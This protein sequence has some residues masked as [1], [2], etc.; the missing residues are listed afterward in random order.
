VNQFLLKQLIGETKIMF[1]Q[2]INLYTNDFPKFR[3]LNSI[4]LIPVCKIKEY[5]LYEKLNKKKTLLNS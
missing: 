5:Q 2:A 4:D 1:G 3:L